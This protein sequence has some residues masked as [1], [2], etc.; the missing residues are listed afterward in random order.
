MNVKR[1]VSWFFW[2]LWVCIV[3][4]GMYL[5]YHFYPPVDLNVWEFIGFFLLAAAITLFPI[6]INGTTIFIVQWVTLAAL[7]TFNL[8]F[9]MLILQLSIILLMFRIGVSKNELYRFASNSLMFFL[10]SF[11]SGIAYFAVGGQVQ[12]HSLQHILGPAFLH[13]I[14]YFVCNHLL[15]FAFRNLSGHKHKFFG[16]DLTWETL[17]ILMVF[18]LSIALYYLFGQIGLPALALLGVPFISA[19]LVLRLYNSTEKINDYLQNAVEIGHQLTQHLQV[20]EV[21]DLFIQKIS[22]T[23]P[24]DYAYIL[25]VEGKELVLIRRVEMGEIKD[26]DLVPLKK[27][28]GISGVVW[29]AEKSVIFDNRS[30]WSGMA[31]GY[32]PENVESILSVPIVRNKRIV[33]VLLLASTRKKA[34]EKYQLM[35]VDM[36]CSYFAV[37]IENARHYEETKRNSERCALTNLYNYRYF[38]N[39][40]T[41]E[42][43]EMRK[44]KRKRISLIMLD[45]DHFKVVNDTYGHQSGNEILVEMADRLNRLVEGFGTLARYGGEEFV[46]LLPDVSKQKATEL[47]ETVRLTI[48]NRPFTLHNNLEHERKRLMVRITASI[49]VAT[50]PEDADD[51]L[52]LIRHAD[53]ALYIGAKRAGRN[54]VAEYVK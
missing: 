28:Q 33:G 15:L 51:A 37:A 22:H 42:Y 4:A 6:A 16:A 47:A 29:A 48:A 44:R 35:I 27:N 52:S 30:E 40:L 8:F 25:S 49:G 38:E 3:P 17:T 39:L 31:K 34:Y 5:T 11:L 18:P 43:V 2:T 1:S 12:D 26:N 9:S 45:I 20:N 23:L 19:S 13:E 41:E 24:V 53:R 36:L 7:M 50:A 46:I 14:V 10:A 54:R 21:L 32:M